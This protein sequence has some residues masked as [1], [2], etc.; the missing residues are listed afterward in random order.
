MWPSLS[1]ALWG[2]GN[3]LAWQ[4]KHGHGLV[5]REKREHGAASNWSC[6]GQNPGLA[7]SAG[8][9]GKALPHEGKGCGLSMI[10]MWG[11]DGL[12]GF[13]SGGKG[14]GQA[15]NGS[16]GLVAWELMVGKMAIKMT[17][18][19]LLVNFPPSCEP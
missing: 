12:R 3:G 16:A 8:K 18:A 14:Y 10:H 1:P 15:A 7:L 11:K 17:I 6:R 5:Y 4:V 19:L 2:E 13:Q 9:E